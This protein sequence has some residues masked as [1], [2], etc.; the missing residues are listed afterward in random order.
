[1]HV[2]CHGGAPKKGAAR[3]VMHALFHGG[4]PK[5]GAARC[6]MHVSC[7]GGA[8]KKG[9]ARL[10]MGLAVCVSWALDMCLMGAMRPM[11]AMM[12]PPNGV[13]GSKWEYMGSRE[14]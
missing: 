4:A 14:G 3:C 11:R 13:D 5:K 6:V 7:H 1:M 10:P 12:S 9:A 2:S 8:P